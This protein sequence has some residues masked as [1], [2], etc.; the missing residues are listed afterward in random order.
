MAQRKITLIVSD[1]KEPV[2]KIRPGVSVELVEI[3]TSGQ[4]DNTKS[5]ATLCG[6]ESTY[7]VALVETQ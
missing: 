4:T 5:L 6:Y 1:D 3:T 2:I 7:C